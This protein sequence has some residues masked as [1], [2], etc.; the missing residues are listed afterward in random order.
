M[1]ISSAVCA[2]GFCRTSGQMVLKRIPFDVP[3]ACPRKPKTRNPS[4]L[5]FE[6]RNCMCRA[7]M[8]SCSAQRPR[9]SPVIGGNGNDYES[10]FLAINLLESGIRIGSGDVILEPLIEESS[11]RVPISAPPPPAIER[12]NSRCSPAKENVTRNFSGT[13]RAGIMHLCKGYRRLEAKSP[14]V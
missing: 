3:F 4:F 9:L 5:T 11:T 12:T 7:R 6:A 2:A 8:A 13:G 10:G 1:T 14:A